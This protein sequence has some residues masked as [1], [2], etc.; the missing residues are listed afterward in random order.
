MDSHGL[1]SHFRTRATESGAMLA[2]GSEVTALSRTED[3]WAVRFRDRDGEN[4]VSASV[5][6]NCAGLG[7]QAV[8]R[9]AGLNPEAMG[10]TL[11]MCKGEYFRLSASKALLV[12]ALVYPVP[13]PNL[14]SLGTHT[15]ADLGGGMKLGP[16]AF[17]VTREDYTVD[18]TN[19]KPFA[20]AVQPYL[21]FITEDDLSPDMAGIRPKLSAEGE[22]ARDFHIREESAAGAAGFVNLVGIDSP[23][24]TAAPAIGNLVARMVANVL[25]GWRACSSDATG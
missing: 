17:Y 2:T 4:E 14:K 5:V 10:L 20:R 18:P 11:R 19:A 6:V 24:L 1:M 25:S 22:P 3:G 7:A 8:M 15:V 13:L 21:P 9:M 12:R 23:G 16:S